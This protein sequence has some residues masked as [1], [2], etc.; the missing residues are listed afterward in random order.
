MSLSL[1]PNFDHQTIF[2]GFV[3]SHLDLFEDTCLELT[4]AESP[5][6][7]KQYVLQGLR[8]VTILA[9]RHPES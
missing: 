9:N 8:G 7:R 1:S 6:N 5:E 4:A 3:Y 2:L